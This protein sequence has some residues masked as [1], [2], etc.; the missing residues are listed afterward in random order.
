MEKCNLKYRNIIPLLRRTKLDILSLNISTIESISS[1][2]EFKIPTIEIINEQ[3]TFDDIID[4]I[5]GMDIIKLELNIAHQKNM[6]I[7]MIFTINIDNKSNIMIFT[8]WDNGINIPKFQQI[9]LKC[10][11]ITDLKIN[12]FFTLSVIKKCG[13]HFNHLKK[14]KILNAETLYYN[15][16][17]DEYDISTIYDGY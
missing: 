6:K 2:L 3:L 13:I 1:L 8:F 16:N 12:K 5:I 9:L 4:N 17:Y 7:N 15:I 11:N 14:I 10:Q